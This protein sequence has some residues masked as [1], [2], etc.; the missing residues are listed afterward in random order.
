MKKARVKNWERANGKKTSFDPR[1][2]TKK[3]IKKDII[4]CWGREKKYAS[5][6][7]RGK[8]KRK[9]ENPFVPLLQRARARQKSPSGEG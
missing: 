5:S 8:E 2:N 1:R 7:A 3:G 4:P 6:K 9:K